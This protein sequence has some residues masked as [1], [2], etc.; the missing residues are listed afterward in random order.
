MYPTTNSTVSFKLSLKG[1]TPNANLTEKQMLAIKAVL[2]GL[3]QKDIA[4][5]MGVTRQA[6]NKWFLNGKKKILESPAF[7]ELFNDRNT[8]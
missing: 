7:K 2:S 8:D 3:E 1:R 5:D 6:V 4:E